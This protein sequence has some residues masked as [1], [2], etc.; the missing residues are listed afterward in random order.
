[1]PQTWNYRQSGIAVASQIELPE[2]APF[3]SAAAKPDLR[4]ELRPPAPLADDLSFHV[5][6]DA[7]YFTTPDVAHYRVTAGERV[8]ITPSPTA[9]ERE[10]RLFLLGS[11][12]GIANYQR[13]NFPLHAGV[14]RVGGHSS[15]GEGVEAN[16]AGCIAFCGASG[17][18]KSSS[19][20]H[21]LRAGFELWSDDLSICRLD[22]TPA[23]WPSTR[24]LKLWRESLDA[25][26]RSAE[27]LERD[28]FREEKFHWQIA[29]PHD[30]SQTPPLP[31]RAVYLLEWGEPSC[32]PLRGIEALRAFVEAATYRGTIL[33]DM[34]AAAPYWEQCA[35]IV[36]Q[37]PVWRLSRPRDW[38]RLPDALRPIL[39][40][41]RP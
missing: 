18:G 38:A 36:R 17:A 1:M 41:W 37:V 35:R 20:A 34:G 7:C 22:E 30:L 23:V 40:Y 8:E 25:L 26:G 6:G 29:A 10:V 24:R 3:A 15:H 4:F 32:V 19:V 9:G 28:Y 16:E 39:E 27:D 13:A 5:E 11:A 12:W 31:L 2:W 14:V 21:L 33:S